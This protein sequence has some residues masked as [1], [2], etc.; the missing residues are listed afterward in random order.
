MTVKFNQYWRIDPEKAQ[1]YE[2]YVL[3]K[4]IQK[5]DGYKSQRYQFVAG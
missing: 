4:F 2:K 3:N 5:V 1:E